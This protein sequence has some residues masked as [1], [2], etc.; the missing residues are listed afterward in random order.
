AWQ[1]ARTRSIVGGTAAD[2]AAGS[3]RH[4]ALEPFPGPRTRD[5]LGSAAFRDEALEAVLS[6]DVEEGLAVIVK[7]LGHRE[8]SRA[9]AGA[10]KTRAPIGEAP[11]DQRA[12]VLI[13]QVEGDEDRPAAPF[14]GLRAE[15]A[16]EKVITRTAPRVAD[17]DLAVDQDALGKAHVAKLR[18]EAQ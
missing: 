12:S 13:E 7:V 6:N 14:R 17:D 16:R 10:E 3:R 4:V 8:D 2:A 5:V 9:E 18:E 15:P 1:R 11:P